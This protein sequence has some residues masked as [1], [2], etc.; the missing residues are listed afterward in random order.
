MRITTSI[1]LSAVL[2][3]MTIGFLMTGNIAAHSSE[4][5]AE[6]NK[7]DIS[8]K[9]EQEVEF[10][11]FIDSSDDKVSAA[12]VKLNYPADMLEYEKEASAKPNKECLANKALQQTISSKN[13]S[14]KGTL[15]LTK[16]MIA[17]TEGLPSGRICFGTF[18][19]KAKSSFWYILPWFKRS[20]KVNFSDAA[21]WQ[22]VGPHGLFEVSEKQNQASLSVTVTN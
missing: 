19:F 8:A 20:G 14:S 3:S 16:V 22:I 13:D 1:L 21:S 4:V 11:L 12:M 15:E 7:S 18:R 5:T 2:C 9:K 17:P 10:N 6:F